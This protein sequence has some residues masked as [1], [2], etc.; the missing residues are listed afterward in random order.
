MIIVAGT[1]D[2]FWTSRMILYQDF[3]CP[4]DVFKDEDIF[5]MKYIEKVTKR[6]IL[7]FKRF[8]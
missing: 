2:V 3:C 1:L 7:K 5:Q 8:L 6:L 4:E